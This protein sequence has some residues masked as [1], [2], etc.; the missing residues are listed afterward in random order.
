MT[1]PATTSPRRLSYAG[2]GARRTPPGVLADIEQYRAWLWREIRT[3][4]IGLDELAALDGKRL[5]CWCAPEPCHGDVLAEAARW[6]TEELR[7]TGD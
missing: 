6:A 1:A 7:P 3:S 4:H 2:I 5:A